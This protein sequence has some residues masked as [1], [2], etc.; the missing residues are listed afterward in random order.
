MV[1]P[2]KRDVGRAEYGENCEDHP[3]GPSPTFS[4]EKTDP[5]RQPY[6]AEKGKHSTDDDPYTTDQG[7]DCGNSGE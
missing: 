6:E 1:N 7:S 3:E 2:G 5:S 4:M